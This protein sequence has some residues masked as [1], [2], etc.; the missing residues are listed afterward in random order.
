MCAT[1]NI[2]DRIC[3]GVDLFVVAV[4]ILECY[5]HNDVSVEVGVGCRRFA[6]KA[7]R[8]GMEDVLILIKKSD[9]FR[10]TVFEDEGLGFVDAFIDELD[11]DTWVEKG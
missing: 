6:M 7:D 3:V 2:V 8:V 11:I 4:V 5:M 1:F 9:V 10:Y